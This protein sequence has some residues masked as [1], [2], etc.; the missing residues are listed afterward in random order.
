MRSRR[1]RAARPGLPSPPPHA[2]AGRHAMRG[3]GG[4]DAA[5]ARARGQRGQLPARA[6]A[7]ASPRVRIH[8]AGALRRRRHRSD[9]YAGAALDARR[10]PPEGGGSA[11]DSRPPRIPN[12]RPAFMSAAV[13]AYEANACIGGQGA[14]SLRRPAGR[15]GRWRRIRR[16]GHARAVR[17]PGAQRRPA[18]RTAAPGQGI[19]HAAGPLAA[20]PVP[21]RRHGGLWAG[22]SRPR[23]RRRAQ[24]ASCSSPPGGGRPAR[25]SSCRARLTAS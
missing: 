5:A 20:G 7:A 2:R 15:R 23:T 21:D 18:R 3:T 22:T 17:E 16:G 10:S 14:R 11:Q 4:Q 8:A 19:A 9:V 12:C 25:R 1:R 13:H 6:C 24:C